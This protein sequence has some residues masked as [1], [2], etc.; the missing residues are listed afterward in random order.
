MPKPIRSNAG[1][2]EKGNLLLIGW[3][4]GNL[5][6][7]KSS[8]PSDSYATAV[9]SFGTYKSAWT[10]VCKRTAC[11]SHESYKMEASEQ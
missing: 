3:N 11:R 8:E 4:H 10:K 1:E 5:G 6:I 7:L 9:K 2:A